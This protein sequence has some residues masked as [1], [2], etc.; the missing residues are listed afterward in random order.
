MVRRSTYNE[1]PSGAQRETAVHPPEDVPRMGYFWR[2]MQGIGK[3]ERIMQNPR[4]RESGV[5]ATLEWKER[6]EGALTGTHN[7][8]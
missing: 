3:P 6:G 5:A 8:K 2:C 4:A 1:H 7:E